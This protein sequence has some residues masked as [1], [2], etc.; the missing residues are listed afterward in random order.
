M[1]PID[2]AIIRRKLGRL[3]AAFEGLGP[4][5]RLSLDDY[6]SRLYERKAAERLLQEAIEAALDINAHVIAELSGD[7]PEDSHQ[8]F[9]RMAALGILSADLA[10][11]LAPSAG[12]RNRL[13]HE[14]D[15]L[16]DE[17]VRDSI[18]VLL[19]LYPRYVQAIEAHLT[20]A[21]F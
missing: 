4:L 21:G 14:Y 6:R 5:A 3:I 15:A 13:V 1:S 18:G 2:A 20:K 12:L 8:G 7:V 16:D 17:K 19:G 9:T 10:H 11:A